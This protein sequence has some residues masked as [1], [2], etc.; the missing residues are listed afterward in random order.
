V[1]KELIAKADK[2]GLK[3]A[4]FIG[5][6]YRLSRRHQ[7]RR[8]DREGRAEPARQLGEQQVQSTSE[9]CRSHSANRRT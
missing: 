9:R 7:A 1:L 5:I 4:P 3:L 8:L 6:A 2:E